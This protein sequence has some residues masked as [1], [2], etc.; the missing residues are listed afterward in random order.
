MDKNQMGKNDPQ[1]DSML[2][3]KTN[4]DFNG[5][6]PNPNN[7]HENELGNV[8]E[9][10]ERKF[11]ENEVKASLPKQSQPSTKHGETKDRK[12]N[13]TPQSEEDETK[14]PVTEKS[15]QLH[16]ATQGNMK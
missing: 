6:K 2:K 1:K 16:S 10:E 12:T 8:G 9:D 7:L 15:K 13:P 4:E 14:E 5:K 3:K 11:K